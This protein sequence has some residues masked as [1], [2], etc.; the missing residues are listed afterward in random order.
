[1]VKTFMIRLTI[2]VDRPTYEPYLEYHLAYL[3]ELSQQG[4]LLLSGPFGDRTGGLLIIEANSWDEAEKIARQ[5]PLVRHG[6]DSY[7]LREWYITDGLR[8]WDTP[9]DERFNRLARGRS[10]SYEEFLE[11]ADEAILTEWV[12]GEV[13]IANP[14]SARQQVIREFLHNVLRIFVGVHKLGIVRMSRFQ[15]KLPRSGREPDLLFV[16]TDHLDRLKAAYLDGPA[17]MVVEIAS[18]ES[19]SRDRGEKF[20]EYEQAGISEYW[21]IDPIREWTECYVLN[22]AGCYEA[23]ISG[24]QGVFCSQALRGFWLKLEWLWQPP[25]ILQTLRELHIITSE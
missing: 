4:I 5:D 13:L 25:P 15:M 6:V 21:L 14:E 16:S 2:L 1:M 7:E 24:R 12:D 10:M 17:D 11:W 22:E 18:Q 9:D 23:L 20:L 3:Q 8:I 19:I